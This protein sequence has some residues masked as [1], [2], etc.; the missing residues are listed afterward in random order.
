MRH[1]KRTAKL[2]RQFE[3]RNAMLANMVCSLIKH[4][5]VTTTL[6]KAK[7]VRSVAEKMVTL[8]KSG[9]IHDRRL[10][11]ARL[12]QQPRSLFKGTPKRK[13]ATDRVAWR[14]NED[15]VH[16]LFDQIA[17]SFKERQGGY[18]RI[19]RLDQRQGDAAQRAILEW[20]DLPVEAAPEPAK[21]D[22]KAAAA[23]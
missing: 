1:L 23:K 10:V 5:R 17:P 7:A 8:G 14:E 15:V 9:T 2:G 4:R 22:K 13:G 6:A 20:V 19:I 12:R 18:T 3:H 11:A 21:E 16:I